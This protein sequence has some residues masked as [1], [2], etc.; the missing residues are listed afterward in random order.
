VPL[1]PTQT[2]QLIPVGKDVI[3]GLKDKYAADRC[4]KIVNAP[5]DS[6]EWFLKILGIIFSAA[7]AAQGAP[8]WFDILKKVVNIRGSGANPD[9]K[10]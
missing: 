8:F 3:W 9:E 10:K 7:A 6:A 2:C 4:Q 1:E 5:A